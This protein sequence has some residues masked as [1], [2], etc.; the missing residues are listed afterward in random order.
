[1][2]GKLQQGLF[3]EGR[4]L[5]EMAPI[6]LRYRPDPPSF[7]VFEG[8][9]TLISNQ[10][11]LIDFKFYSESADLR[12]L[13]DFVLEVLP[14]STIASA[15]LADL[16]L[17]G[18]LSRIHGYIDEESGIGMHGLLEELSTNSHKGIPQVTNLAGSLYLHPN[19]FL[20][21]LDSSGARVRFPNVFDHLWYS[22]K[23][24][25]ELIS[26]F[27]RDYF[28]LVNRNIQSV[29]REMEVGGSFSVSRAISVC[30]RS[31]ALFFETK[32]LNL[33]D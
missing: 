10:T 12:S 3:P 18:K 13:S 16:N 23:L 31:L 15:W 7:G 4:E 8:L 24:T 17:E 11:S 2:D 25:G 9:R 1:M 30:N 29:F 32:H 14:D 28:S 5:L 6:W 27:D 33:S 20:F 22:E 19:G 21:E 26:W